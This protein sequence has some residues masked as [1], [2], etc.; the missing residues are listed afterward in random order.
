MILVYHLQSF[1]SYYVVWV[2]VF[3]YTLCITSMT[4]RMCRFFCVTYAEICVNTTPEDHYL[5]ECC[6][7]KIQ[8]F[9]EPMI[10]LICWTLCCCCCC[11]TLGLWQELRKQ[12]HGHCMCGRPPVF[13]TKLLV[14]C[15]LNIICCL[16]DIELLAY[17]VN[18]IQYPPNTRAEI[19]KKNIVAS[20][21]WRCLSKF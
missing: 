4:L 6:G 10:V 5:L 2:P 11:F 13:T 3:A 16:V 8:P 9:C 7:I 15:E 14:G 19:G 20:N 17:Q 18:K 12:H 21:I 1:S